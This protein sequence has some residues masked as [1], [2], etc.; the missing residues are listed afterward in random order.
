MW[1]RALFGLIAIFGFMYLLPDIV[2]LFVY[3]GETAGTIKSVQRK[4]NADNKAQYIYIVDGIT[5]WGETNWSY[6]NV[7]TEG[8][9][10]NVRY[11]FEHPDRSYIFSLGESAFRLFFGFLLIVAGIVACIYSGIFAY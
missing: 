10:C 5:Y 2:K 3:R 6:R 7:Y 1:V 8:S 9:V 11:S 4:S